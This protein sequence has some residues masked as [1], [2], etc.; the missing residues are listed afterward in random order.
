ME[1]PNTSDKRL[2]NEYKKEHKNSE[3]KNLRKHVFSSKVVNPLY[4]CHLTPFYRERKGLLH[5]DIALRSK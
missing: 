3:T 4:T 1:P 2:K 5:S